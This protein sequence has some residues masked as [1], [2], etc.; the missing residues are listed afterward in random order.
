MSVVSLKSLLTSAPVFEQKELQS[1]NEAKLE[2]LFILYPKN[3]AS[4][5]ASKQEDNELPWKTVCCR[6]Y[7]RC[8][9]INQYNKQQLPSCTV[10]QPRKQ[11]NE[12]P[13][14]Y[15]TVQCRHFA[16]DGSCKYK[17][18]CFFWHEVGEMRKV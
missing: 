8:N 13:W 6:Y 10:D 12:L 15:K 5:Q 4:N 11:V 7:G 1:N 3:Q 17:G 18:K 14:N 16:R 9:A 2:A